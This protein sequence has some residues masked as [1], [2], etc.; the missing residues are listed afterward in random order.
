MEFPRSSSINS[1]WKPSSSSLSSSHQ[2]KSRVVVNDYGTAA[3]KMACAILELLADE[4]KL[5]PRNVFS[6]LLMD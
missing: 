1:S 3:K 2:R 4:M 6:K 5:Q